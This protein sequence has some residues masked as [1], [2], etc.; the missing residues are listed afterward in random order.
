LIYHADFL[1]LVLA[2]W[3]EMHSGIPGCP[4]HLL[5]HPILGLWLD[6]Y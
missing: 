5:M 1:L 3:C 6:I 2:G 4:N